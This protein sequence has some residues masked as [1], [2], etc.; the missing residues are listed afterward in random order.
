MFS[1]KAIQKKN[2]RSAKL[3]KQ[4]HKSK[5]P[6][7][8]KRKRSA[9]TAEVQESMNTAH[10]LKSE[11]RSMFKKSRKQKILADSVTL[12]VNG[13]ESC[14]SSQPVVHKA[15]PSLPKEAKKKKYNRT[16]KITKKD[17]AKK[18]SNSFVPHMKKNNLGK[19][20]KADTSDNSQ[21]GGENAQA[22]T[23]NN[24]QDGGE[25]AQADTSNNSQDGGETA[26]FYKIGDS[27]RIQNLCHD[28]DSDSSFMDI[29]NLWKFVQKDKQK[30]DTILES[31]SF[32]EKQKDD[33]ILESESSKEKQ[34]GIQEKS[35]TCSTLRQRERTKKKEELENKLK[36][37]GDVVSAIGTFRD[38]LVIAL[39]PGSAL[40]IQG[41]LHIRP[42]VGTV[43]VLGYTLQQRE[44]QTMYSF[45]TGALL[46]LCTVDAYIV[47]PSDK[48]LQDR[49]IPS[50]WL[51]HVNRKQ[52]GPLGIIELQKYYPPVLRLL[53]RAGYKNLFKTKG[54]QN[55]WS[56]MGITVVTEANCREFGLLNEVPEWMNIM[57]AIKTCWTCGSVPRVVVCGARAVGKSTFFRYISNSLLCE[58][59]ESGIMCLDLD[60][61]QSEF[62]LPTCISLI[63]L[64]KPL[65]GAACV[66]HINE[67]A[68]YAKQILV[69]ET[70]PKFMLQKYMGA[71]QYLHQLSLEQPS[72]PLV[73]NTM[74]WTRGTGLDIMLD[75][76]RIIKP[77]HVIQIQSSNH[78]NNF[79]M[80][81][82]CEKVETV[83]GGIITNANETELNYRLL[84]YLS[85][86]RGY[87]SHLSLKPNIVRDLSVITHVGQFIDLFQQQEQ[88]KTEDKTTNVVKL[89]WSSIV[90]HVC[91]EQIPKKR[92]LQVING[93]L[94]ALCEVRH[95]NVETVGPNLPKQ[96]T[97]DSDFGNLAGWG[98]ISGI[99]P[100]TQELY[101]LTS[102]LPEVVTTQVNAV[103]MP[104]LFLPES[105]YK[106]FS[107]GEAPY[108][109]RQIREGA[110]QLKVERQIKPRI[111][112]SM[113]D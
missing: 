92:I 94:V 2:E 12:D 33:T 105:A 42:L 63:Q 10:N 97:E 51:E 50:G 28:S 84:V 16:E 25:K 64:I 70:S 37:I 43:K 40:Y 56:E 65:L 103:I 60:L 5:P 22:D 82:H 57:D 72:I 83:K 9:A 15:S 53:S 78:A 77:T 58:K 98:I 13:T 89:S 24:S 20:C 106:L 18:V 55:T 88:K 59:S 101:I 62:S 23:S 67:L 90:L 21:D 41:V 69:G 1:L 32:S 74:G 111:H 66:H 107:S 29:S 76:L 35:G 80:E 11:G 26:Q 4:P 46:C 112:H 81:L 108:L 47:D 109:H 96:L 3:H 110:G 36:L 73:V 99:D 45:A 113:I 17:K 48:Y 87:A 8:K 75:I 31:E 39:S 30:D 85:T 100:E 86:I 6:A 14:N 68:S 52:A 104:K 49:G 27:D 34:T 71:V 95:D 44:M 102:L 93:Q 91:D 54:Y 19:S 7:K 61:G 38:T 79:P